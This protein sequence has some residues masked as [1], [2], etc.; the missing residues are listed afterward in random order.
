MY[1]QIWVKIYDACLFD[2]RY[3]CYSTFGDDRIWDGYLVQV[4]Q[5]AGYRVQEAG[6]L[7]EA[8]VVSIRL[9]QVHLLTALDQL[10]VHQVHILWANFLARLQRK[11][12]RFLHAFCIKKTWW[13]MN[14]R[15]WKIKCEIILWTTQETK[16]CLKQ[17]RQY[18]YSCKESISSNGNGQLSVCRV[19]GLNDA[20]ELLHEELQL[21]FVL[22]NISC[23]QHCNL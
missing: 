7:V 11:R 2:L 19:H 17:S 16:L 15:R 20:T 23:H 3:C 5:D 14:G 8:V 9:G 21:V 22:L 4:N 18:T 1:I 10:C 12:R 6:Q 13:Y